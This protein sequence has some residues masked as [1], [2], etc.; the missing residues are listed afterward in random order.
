M[1]SR[2]QEYEISNKYEE[3]YRIDFVGDEPYLLIEKELKLKI[4]NVIRHLPDRCREVFLLSRVN[5]MKNKE[6]AEKLHINI[7]N[8]ERHLKRAL[9]SFRQGFS[10]EF[11]IAIVI[12]VLKN[13]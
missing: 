3:L 10:D 2:L 11:P 13:L 7:K 8:V 6:I 12:L 9:F 5:G 4:N 1:N